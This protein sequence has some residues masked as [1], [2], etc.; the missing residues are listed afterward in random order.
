MS[1]MNFSILIPLA[2]EGVVVTPSSLQNEIFFLATWCLSSPSFS[3]HQ[4]KTQSH[5][6]VSWSALYSSL[7]LTGAAT[8]GVWGYVPPH[9]LKIWVS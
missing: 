2:C 8:E 4:H 1:K 9:F 5:Q 6:T 3:L 7:L